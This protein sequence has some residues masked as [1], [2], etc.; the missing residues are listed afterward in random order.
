MIFSE[1]FIL[2]FGA[3]FYVLVVTFLGEHFKDEILQV[4]HLVFALQLLSRM[5]RCQVFQS[6][7][8]A[9]A[10]EQSV[11]CHFWWLRGTAVYTPLLCTAALYSVHY[12]TLLYSVCVQA[13][14]DA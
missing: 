2:P 11:S 6:F 3:E 12:C 10:T 7:S 5:T 4:L 13:G 8:E 1:I 14:P 9:E